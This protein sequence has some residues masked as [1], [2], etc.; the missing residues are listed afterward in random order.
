M[1][2]LGCRTHTLFEEDLMRT[3]IAKMALQYVLRALLLLGLTSVFVSGAVALTQTDMVSA[4]D[5]Y[6]G[7]TVTQDDDGSA[8]DGGEDENSADQ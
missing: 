1:L 2:L 5:P 3:P 4:G 7:Q 8:D 6:N